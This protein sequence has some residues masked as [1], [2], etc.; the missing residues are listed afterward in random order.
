MVE[1][2]TVFNGDFFFLQREAGQ[3]LTTFYSALPS[4]SQV[5]S[6]LTDLENP[7]P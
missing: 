4:V 5:E 1:K 7:F 2:I 3:M 6:L